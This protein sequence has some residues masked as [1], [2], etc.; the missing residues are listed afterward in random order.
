MNNVIKNGSGFVIRNIAILLIFISMNAE[1]QKMNAYLA[2]PTG[3]PR[4]HQLDLERMKLEVNFKP[5]KGMVIGKVTYYFSPIRENVDSIFFDAPKIT[6]DEVRINNKVEKF[7]MNDAGMTVFPASPLHWKSKDSITITY[8]CI[9]RRGIYFIGWNA[10]SPTSRKQIWTQGQG[11]D[12]RYWIPSYD[13]MDD[14]LIT[15]T[16]VTFDKDY[17]VLSNGTKLAE[18][19]NNN[20]T[21]TWHYS[22][23][24][25]HSSY[26]VMLG[27]GKYGIKNTVSKNGVKMYNYYYEDQA[28]CEIP[29]YRGAEKMMDF[30]EMETGLRY[31]WESYSQIPVQDFMFGAMENTTATVYGDFLY[32]DERAFLDRSYMGVDAHEMT[33]QWFG[34]YVTA[35]DGKHNW[36]QES[37]ATYYSKI[38]MR[39]Y[40]GEDQYQWNRRGE[41]N[42]ALTASKTDRNPIVHT[43]GGGARSYQK[44]SATLDMLRY[45]SGDEQFKFGIKYYLDHHPYSNVETNDL[46][47]AF[48]DGMGLNYDWFFDEWLYKSGEPVYDVSYQDVTTGESLESTDIQVLQTQVVD[49]QTGLFKM[50][51]V[52]SVYYKDGSND[53][54]REWVEKQSTLVRIPNPMHKKINYV[55]F[56]PGS[57]V[58]KTVNF[59]K[60]IEELKAQA[61]KAPMMIDRYD[62]LLGLKTFSL[63][64][65]RETLLNLF[66]KETF[67][68]IKSEILAQLNGDLN[69]DVTV[70]LFDM[71]LKDKDN[72]V[73][74]AAVNNL[75]D[76]P[77]ELQKDVE[78]LLKDSSYNVVEATLEKLST[79]YPDK[80]KDY[81][82]ATKDVYGIGN[83]IKIKWLE[84]NCHYNIKNVGDSY[85]Q[86]VE[87]ASNK[88]EFRTRVNSF[89]ALQRL[90]YINDEFINNLFDASLYTNSRLANPAM[91]V[92]DFYYKTSENKTKIQKLYKALKLEPWQT[93]ILEKYGR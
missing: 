10:N 11:V 59:K 34:D 36:L 39:S 53:T 75:F 51:I 2:D 61:L 1:A 35:I 28:N 42:A 17:K 25:P 80:A 29:T 64:E 21:K 15:E 63:N 89:N 78:K 45:V 74:L 9:P 82:D 38:F 85:K 19:S 93:T 77:N 7:S 12:N 83:S 52:F 88:Y 22:M 81:L 37:F 67:H 68:A 62:A 87:M 76:I 20:G 13:D 16:I 26:L 41:H 86:L 18:T 71:A 47:R 24:H 48:F 33:H 92:L 90:D 40:Y 91:G 60:T 73:R 49:E 27:I 58:L 79:L 44:G 54:K 66:K 6:I 50:P 57:I 84:I 65:K 43:A 72:N 14:K 3:T 46:F 55:L 69:T 32:V 8:N 23:T 70:S 31:P 56:D 30:L 5:E 4:E